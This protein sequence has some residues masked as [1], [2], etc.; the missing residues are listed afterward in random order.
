MDSQADAMDG[1]LAPDCDQSGFVATHETLTTSSGSS[2]RVI[3]AAY[4]VLQP[5]AVSPSRL[6]ELAGFGDADTKAD[7]D[8]DTVPPEGRGDQAGCDEDVALAVTDAKALCG[9][10]MVGDSAMET[11]GGSDDHTADKDEGHEAEDEDEDREHEYHGQEASCPRPAHPASTVAFDSDS[12][13][14]PS[15]RT[16]STGASTSMQCTSTAPRSSLSSSRSRSSRAEYAF[17]AEAGGGAWEASGTGWIGGWQGDGAKGAS[18][19]S[20][21]S[22]Q[23]TVDGQVAMS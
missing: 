7:A 5:D 23:G 17:D 9:S 12:G 13:F 18:S 1:I 22:R 19:S 10:R 15:C 8:A 2:V 4:C 11:A 6:R 21:L 14:A 20:S 3:R 16:T